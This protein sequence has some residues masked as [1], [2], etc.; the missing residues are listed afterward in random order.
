LHVVN[1]N[2]NGD[3][4]T[5]R[6]VSFVGTPLNRFA[7]PAEAGLGG[8]P[9]NKL[10]NDFRDVIRLNFRP[11][12]GATSPSHSTSI[13]NTSSRREREMVP[14]EHDVGVFKTSGLRCLHPGILCDGYTRR[15]QA[16]ASVLPF[17]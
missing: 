7:R 9:D 6:L 11:G 14:T 17:P 13:I 15:N 2:R 4:V 16:P 12:T 10:V 8:D 5:V 3:G 1:A